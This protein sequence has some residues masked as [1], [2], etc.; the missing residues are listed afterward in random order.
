MPAMTARDPL[1]AKLLAPWHWPAWLGLGVLWLVARLP[2]RTGLR[3]GAGLGPLLHLLLV[4][5][6][7]IAQ[8]NIELCFPELPPAGRE[9][10]LREHFR[11]LG[12]MFVEFALGW[13]AP[14]RRFD[15]IP[16][17]IDG[18]EHLKAALAGGRGVLMV[19]AHF[20]HLELC[21]RL[22]GQ[23][24]PL[25]GMYREHGSPVFEWAIKRLRLRYAGQMFGRREL[26]ATVRYLKRGGGLWYAPDQDMRG[27]DSVFAPFFGIAA[28]TITA[29]HHL[30]RMSGTAVLMFAHRRLPGDQGYLLELSPPLAGFPSDDAVAD[31]ARI[32]AGIEAMVRA[33]PSQYLWIHRR[34]KTRPPGDPPNYT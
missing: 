28:S 19:G 14:A 34:F 4:R 11:D 1:P 26:R 22:I 27:K 2:W 6:R 31:S 30:A 8:R 9:A 17:R 32:N 3:F 10:L 12:R 13:M 20:T 16:Y 7:R 25:A 24:V 15:A 29:T 5:R 33:A 18:L 23:A 21:A